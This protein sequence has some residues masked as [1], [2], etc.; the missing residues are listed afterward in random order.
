MMTDEMSNGDRIEWFGNEN[1]WLDSPHRKDEVEIFLQEFRHSRITEKKER[2]FD[3]ERVA[4]R[5]NYLVDGS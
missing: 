5:S 1:L 2:F 3:F 4:R